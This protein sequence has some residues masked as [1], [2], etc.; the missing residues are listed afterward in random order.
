MS[1]PADGACDE[2]DRPIKRSR[3]LLTAIVGWTAS[4]LVLA[5]F[6]CERM[7]SLRLVAI[8]SNV[9]FIGYACL[10]HLWPILALHT[11]MLPLN[12][13]RL[14]GALA[15][16]EDPAMRCHSPGNHA[17]SVSVTRATLFLTRLP[18]TW[19]ERNRLRRE[20]ST[21]SPHDFGDL[22]IPPGMIFD[23]C[24]RWPWQ[25]VSPL[26]RTV[27]EWRRPVPSRNQ[28]P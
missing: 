28:Y 6:C 8:A 20:L 10:A 16:G 2:S 4:G 7:V 22:P 18:Q 15:H 25:N 19:R 14:R 17:V 3:P 26:W 9:A 12:I 13:W 1:S 21:M 11:I 5:A 24:R 27:R 23:E